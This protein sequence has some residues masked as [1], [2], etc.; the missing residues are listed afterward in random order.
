MLN[1][2]GVKHFPVG[3][4]IFVEGHVFD[5]QRPHAFRFRGDDDG[6][7][8]DNAGPW[9]SGPLGSGAD[10]GHDLLT[11]RAGAGMQ[12]DGAVRQFAG[13]AQGLRRHG[14]DQYRDVLTARL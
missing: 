10:N 6:D 12:R 2:L 11:E 14:R 1:T 3:R 8:G 13:R 9:P 5:G 7:T 4:D